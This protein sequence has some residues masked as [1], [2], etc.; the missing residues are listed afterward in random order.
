MP[1]PAA[2]LT[3]PHPLTMEQVVI[4][5]AEALRGGPWLAVHD[6]VVANAA[7]HAEATAGVQAAEAS[8]STWD[9]INVLTD[10][11]AEAHRDA[12]AARAAEAAVAERAARAQ[13][14]TLL[15]TALGVYPPG[16]AYYALEPVRAQIAAVRAVLRRRTH[17][18]RVGNVTTTSTSYHCELLGKAEA[19]AALRRWTVGA[20]GVFGRL[21]PDG[22]ILAR[23]WSR[24]LRGP[25]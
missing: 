21:P 19:L 3:E 6:H 16:A 12:C 24:A 23:V 9:R 10:T 8:I 20:T 17:T 11:P 5:V 14:A 18:R 2:A 4:S 25:G 13:L 1:S 22:E 15:A 7:A